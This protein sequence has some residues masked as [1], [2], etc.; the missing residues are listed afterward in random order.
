MQKSLGKRKTSKTNY[1]GVVGGILP[2]SR[3]YY[4]KPFI[5]SH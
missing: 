5:G 4:A 2:H 1:I 3:K